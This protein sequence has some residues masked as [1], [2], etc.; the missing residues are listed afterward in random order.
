MPAH[1]MSLPERR[2]TFLQAVNVGRQLPSLTRQ[3]VMPPGMLETWNG[4]TALWDK[5]K[6]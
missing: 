6:Q 1:V 3:T 2:C 5:Q 4:G